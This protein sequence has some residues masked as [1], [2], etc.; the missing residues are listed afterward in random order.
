MLGFD[1]AS[2]V[3]CWYPAGLA[4]SARSTA[5][6]QRI[7][8]IKRRQESAPLAIC[9]GDV[10][11]VSVYGDAGHLPAGLLEQ[12]LPGPTTVVLTTQP[13][14][15]F[16]GQLHCFPH[17]RL[18]HIVRWPFIASTSSFENPSTDMT[19]VVSQNGCLPLGCHC[20]HWCSHSNPE[21]RRDR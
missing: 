2:C 11:D 17:L 3:K 20:V 18:L 4:A 14:H 1:P 5:A 15:L 8:D 16:A 7:Y 9:I 10:H 19:G 6:V 21:H 12:L 13:A